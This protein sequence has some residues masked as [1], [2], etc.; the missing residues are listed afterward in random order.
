MCLLVKAI[1]QVVDA[2][3][4]LIANHLGRV[5]AIILIWL[6]NAASTVLNAWILSPVAVAVHRMILLREETPGLIAW[7]HPRIWNFFGW[8]LALELV[9]TIAALPPLAIP[10]ASKLLAL[11][12]FGVL[13]IIVS[14]R[15]LLIFPAV[16]VETPA[17]NWKKRIEASWV[18][19][20]GLFWTLLLSLFG[21]MLILY[22]PLLAIDAIYAVFFFSSGELGLAAHII[23]IGN[24]LIDAVLEPFDVALAAAVASWCYMWLRQD[25]RA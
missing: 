12:V 23:R 13:G 7:N 2:D 9:L 1:D 11:I 6:W 3:A 20:R 21:A 10:N 14:V 5:G 19:T 24:D 15:S 8:T 4:A 25:E 17:T 18:S 22:L 16:A